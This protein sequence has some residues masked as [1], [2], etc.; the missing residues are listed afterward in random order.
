[1]GRRSLVPEDCSQPIKLHLQRVRLDQGG[2]DVCGTYWGIGDPIYVAGDDAGTAEITLRAPT[3]EWA[4]ELVKD[5]F[6]KARF[7]R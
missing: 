3:R 2:Y 4:K 5:T 1:M 6:P 7:Y